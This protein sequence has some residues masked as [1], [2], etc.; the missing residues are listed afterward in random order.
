MSLAFSEEQKQIKETAQRFF[1]E[2]APVEAL[3]KLRDSNDSQG[4]SRE[5]WQQMAELGFAGINIPEAYDGLGMGIKDLGAICEEAGHT[6]AVSPLF[7]TT[8]LCANLLT[9]AGSETQKQQYLPRMASGDCTAAL[10][11]DE[12]NHHEPNTVNNQANKTD[13]GYTL[14]GDKV[15]VLDGHSAELLIVVARLDNKPAFFLL[16]SGHDGVQITRTQMLDNRN[17]ARI[18]LRDVQLASDAYLPGSSAETLQNTLDRARTCL[19]AEMLGGAQEVFNR[20]V[21]YLKEREQFG[22]KIATFQALRHRIAIVFS[23]LELTRSCIMAA[24]DAIDSGTQ[25][26]ELAACAS[27]AKASANECYA[28]AC[29]EAVQMHG[30]IGVTDEL[31]IGFFLKRSRVAIHLLGDTDFHRDRYAQLQNY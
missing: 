4:Y 19:A 5:L 18:S 1:V 17:A 27:L 3:R 6:L 15:L 24:L 28:L 16:P 31:E 12:G 30:G 7:A 10:A 11:L 8:I 23:E 20:T 26:D 13:K 21:E 2:N 22:V 9:E 29:K 25:G 14:N